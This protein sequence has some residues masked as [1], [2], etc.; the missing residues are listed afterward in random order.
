MKASEDY[1]EELEALRPKIKTAKEAIVVTKASSTQQS[2][3]NE[4]QE[5]V[6]H[7]QT[8]QSDDRN[9]TF[10]NMQRIVEALKNIKTE[11]QK[12]IDDKSAL[13]SKDLDAK[14]AELLSE[15]RDRAKTIEDKVLKLDNMILVEKEFVKKILDII[16][17]AYPPN[18]IVFQPKIKD[19]KQENTVTDDSKDKEVKND[20]AEKEVR[21]DSSAGDVATQSET[22]EEAATPKD[23]VEKDNNVRKD[24]TVEKDDTTKRDETIEK[25]E[26]A[27]MNGSSKAEAKESKKEKTLDD[28]VNELRALLNALATT[29]GNFVTELLETIRK[30][31]KPSSSNDGVNEEA[32]KQELGVL[33][34]QLTDSQT[35][36]SDARTELT[37]ADKTTKEK[38]LADGIKA[39]AELL[40]G[41]QSVVTGAHVALTNAGEKN[42]GKDLADRIKAFADL[43]EESQEKVS[44]AKAAI[45][46]AHEETKGMSLADGVKYLIET[47]RS[48]SD[49]LREAQAKLQSQPQPQSNEKVSRKVWKSITPANETPAYAVSQFKFDARSRAVQQLNSD[50]SIQWDKPREESHPM[51]VFWLPDQGKR[52]SRP[53]NS[54]S[55]GRNNTLREIANAFG[56]TSQEILKASDIKSLPET[57]PLNDHNLTI[58]AEGPFFQ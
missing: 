47:I 14:V 42:T 21:Q 48:L 7:G 30:A 16:A 50:S 6:Q 22:K 57:K 44:S 36:I 35:E 5:V 45:Q 37:A 38:S 51:V 18:H 41:N 34:Q 53:F 15:S 26:S 43:L 28:A 55:L 19:D 31:L 39:L 20:T 27:T 40:T 10:N 3:S 49:A 13:S 33:V 46:A 17:G 1:K 2:E 11:C 4:G 32:V 9:T 12:D 24:D 58:P 23:N 52:P 56:V 29:R 8:N 25:G 54:N